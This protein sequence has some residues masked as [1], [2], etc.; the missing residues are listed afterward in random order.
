MNAQKRRQVKQQKAQRARKSKASKKKKEDSISLLKSAAVTLLI[1][2]LVIVNL[3]LIASFVSKF[4]H[5]PSSNEVAIATDADLQQLDP[6]QQTN[7]TTKPV[8]V[9]VLNGC[10][11]PGIAKQIMSLLQARGF[12][13]VKVGNYDSYNINETMVID[14][15][16]R[17]KVNAI[18][19]ANVLGVNPEHGVAPFLNPDLMLDVTVVIGHDYKKLT[20]FQRH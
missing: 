3:F 20:P 14:R 7:P 18:K 6:L 17:N 19:V 4:W 13:V 16:S 15:R 1:W 10:G 11:V 9:E 5:E 2:G 8:Q 12:D